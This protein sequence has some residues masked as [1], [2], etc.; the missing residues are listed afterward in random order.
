MAQPSTIESIDPR[1]IGVVKQQAGSNVRP[2]LSGKTPSTGQKLRGGYYTPAPIANF[3][4]DWAVQDGVSHI[5]EPSA[6]DGEIVV[7]IVKRLGPGGRITAVELDP[8]EATKAAA[9]GGSCTTVINDDFFSWFRDTCGDSTVDA[10]IGNPPFIRFGDFP[11][12]YRQPAF[13]VMRDEGLHPTKLTNMWLPFVVAS[14]RALRPGGRLALVLPAEL[15]QVTYAG[16]LRE[17]LVRKYAQ[18]TVVTFRRLVFSGIQQ[19]TVLLLGVRQDD[20]TAQISFVGLDDIGDLSLDRVRGVV[21][22]EADLHHG[23]EKWTQYYLSPV[24]LGLIRELEEGGMFGRLGQYAEVD[25]GVVT[26][27]NQF[28]VMTEEEAERNGVRSACVPLVGRSA[29]VP[30]L[31][32]RQEDWNHLVASNGRVLLMQLGK[33]ERSTLSEKALAYVEYGESQN[34]HEGYKCDLRMPSWWYVPSVWV[35]DA[36]LLRQIHDGPR[37][38]ENRAGA[39]STD[40]IHRVRTKAGVNAHWLAAASVNSLTFAFAEIRGRSY[41]GGVLELE[42][43]EAEGLPFPKPGPEPLPV[44]D[45]DRWVRTKGLDSALDEIDRRVLKTAGLDGADI[46]CLKGIWLKLYKRRLARKQ[47]R[48]SD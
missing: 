4:A 16:E 2:L 48:K 32:L 22:V 1:A 8:D 24:E 33:T 7:S 46:A 26:G 25:V 21:P 45:L 42:P 43:T 20:A 28:F 36:F 29:Q 15:L 14:T 30:G 39:T 23:R 40:T 34:I 12:K 38:I 10:V 41:G 5:L 37:I 11:D 19:E 44:D 27:F 47:R 3:L 31:V 9:R 6:G 17:Y 13:E 18:L 35:P